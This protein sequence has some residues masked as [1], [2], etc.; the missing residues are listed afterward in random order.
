MAQCQSCNHQIPE[1]ITHCPYCGNALRA[2]AQPQAEK[3]TVFGYAPAPEEL[4]GLAQQA[5]QPQ[6]PAPAP[7]QAPAQAPFQAQAPAPAPASFQPPVGQPAQAPPP[8]QPFSPPMGS[9]QPLQAPA[10]GGAVPDDAAMAKTMFASDVPQPGAPPAQ[11]P[12]PSTVASEPGMPSP[13]AVSGPGAGG[14]PA[15]AP[16]AGAPMA[17][18][19]PGAPAP[20]APMAAPPPGGAPQAFPATMAVPPG[21]APPMGAPPPGAPA[22]GAPMGAPPPGAPMAAPPPGAPMGAPMAAPPPGAPM[23]A[24]MAAPGMA[25]PQAAP[26]AGLTRTPSKGVSTALYMILV[27]GMLVVSGVLTAI[28]VANMRKM[29]ELLFFSWIPIIPGLV[30]YYILMYKAWAAIH[31]EQSKVSPGGAVGLMF[32]PFFNIYWLFVAIGGYGKHYNEYAQR[33]GLQARASEGL[34]IAAAVLTLLGPL[35][36]VALIMIVLGYCGAINQL[37]S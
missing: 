10:A 9:G 6:A 31:D 32:V 2:E 17:A 4:Q 11:A 36:I 30:F 1:N 12:F 8:G 5:A 14:P 16:P 26:M 34:F 3:R 35:S 18:P 22:P 20:G 19:P 25:A 37:K 33:H 27:V 15:G 24:P 28:G 21:T 7:A 23:R 13:F 29:H